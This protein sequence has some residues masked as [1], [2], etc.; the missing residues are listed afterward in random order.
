MKR[1][2]GVK[3]KMKKGGTLLFTMLTF[4]TWAQLP[5]Q[6]NYQAVVR[7]SNGQPVA[8]NS[9]IKMRFTIHD[10]SVSGAVVF[11]ETATVASNS[12]GLVTYVI[13]SS[14]NLG[15]VNCG[16]ANK[17]LQVEVDVT[18]GNNYIDMGTTQLLSVPY[19]LYANDAASVKQAK[20]LLYLS[21]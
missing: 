11:Q 6:M 13:G 9:N 1:L 20:T 18:G 5:Q 21:H 10:N 17:F 19:A 2:S 14:S 16:S 12:L 3:N 8:N 15:A 7:N 4:I